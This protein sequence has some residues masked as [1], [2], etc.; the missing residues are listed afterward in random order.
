M[1]HLY[2]WVCSS[3]LPRPANT[4]PPPTWKC[5]NSTLLIYFLS[6]CAFVFTFV[7]A[8]VFFLYLL[9]AFAPPCLDMT[10]LLQKCSH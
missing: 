6:D 5:S 9:F 3:S 2:H 8:F 4:L 7:F 10:G 1:I